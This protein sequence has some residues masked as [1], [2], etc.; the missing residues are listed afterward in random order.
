MAYKPG[1]YKVVCDICGLVFLRSQC[2]KNWKNQ[3]VCI[4]DYEPKHPQLSVKVRP[5]KARV[6]DARP[7]GE[8]QFLSPGDVTPDDL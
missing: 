5:E 8:D 4:A 1:D 3:V 6:L 7:E 2:R